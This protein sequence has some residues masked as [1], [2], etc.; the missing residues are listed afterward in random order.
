MTFHTK[1]SSCLEKNKKGITNM[2]SAE[3]A[4]SAKYQFSTGIILKYISYFVQETRF[5]ISC[6]PFPVETVC[7]K[8]QIPLDEKR[9]KSICISKDT[10]C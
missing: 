6:K 10:V 1:Y 8:C 7:M 4:Q 3:I 2:L 5:D 9:K